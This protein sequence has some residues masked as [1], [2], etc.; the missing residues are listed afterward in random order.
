MQRNRTIADCG[1]G[2]VA[3]EQ[4]CK[5]SGARLTPLRRR[6]LELVLACGKPV[7]AYSLLSELRADGYSDAPP[8]IYRT[9]EFLRA[10]GLVHRIA[11]SSTFVACC[12]PR[13]GHCGLIFVCTGCGGAMELQE[14]EIMDDITQRAAGLGYRIPRQIVE[15]E[16]VCN[17]CQAVS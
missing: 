5:L 12:R 16:G 13:N 15:I 3:A 6:V 14:Q 2:L 10:H 8:T 9:L 4:V 17:A 1:K 11:K 7:G